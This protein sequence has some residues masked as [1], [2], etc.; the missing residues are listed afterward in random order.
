MAFVRSRGFR[1]LL[2]VVGFLGLGTL[3]GALG[4][5]L[6]FMRDLPDLRSID[7]YRPPLASRVY[8]RSGAP[9]GSFFTERRELTPLEDVPSHVIDAFVASRAAAPS[10]SRW[11]RGCCSPR[12][13]PT[14]ARSAR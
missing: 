11:S 8:D 7:D 5:Y 6:A 13:A 9:V 10:P 3:L 14:G 2:A 12:S 4:F 1:W